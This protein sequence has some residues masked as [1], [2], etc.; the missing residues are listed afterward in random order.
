MIKTENGR[1][2]VGNG[3]NVNY[4]LLVAVKTCHLNMVILLRVK[5]N[6]TWRRPQE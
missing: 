6:F 4:R 3:K 2:R 1:I 5:N